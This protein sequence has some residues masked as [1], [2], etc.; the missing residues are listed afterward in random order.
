MNMRTDFQ[1]PEATGNRWPS[2][3]NHRHPAAFTLVELLIIIAIIGVLAAFIL[4]A[5]KAAKR[6][7]YLKTAQAELNQTITALE[8]Y[9]AR[10]GTYPPGNPTS[11]TVNQLYYELTGTPPPGNFST[12]F[13]V[14]GLVNS[15]HGSG[16]DAAA[17][18]NFLPGLKQNQ[19]GTYNGDN[20]IITSARGPDITYQP[21][22]VQD[23]NPFRYRYPGTN[24]P[25]SYDL[26][27]QLVISGQ[28]N[29]ICNWTKQ[30]QIN[31]S[32]P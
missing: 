10:Y 1:R 22:S 21:L 15:A 26:W 7:Q 11:Y 23:V 19:I 2:G 24:N 8:N 3:V 9:K 4:T 16:D 14:G 5:S 13:G 20:I 27:V 18:K 32:L 29:L 6:W 28:T 12:T 17:A 31:N 30:I 25:S